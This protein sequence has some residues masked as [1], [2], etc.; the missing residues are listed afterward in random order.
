M[1]LILAES[2]VKNKNQ[3]YENSLRRSLIKLKWFYWDQAG[4]AQ[5]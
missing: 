2:G 4:T 1:I 3:K 5:K